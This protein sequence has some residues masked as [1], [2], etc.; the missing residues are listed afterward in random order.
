M[1]R[2][3]DHGSPP[4]TAS[5]ALLVPRLRGRLRRDGDLRQARLRRRRRRPHAAVRALRDRG[6]GAV[7]RR[8]AAPRARSS[9]ADRA[10]A[11]RRA[12]ARRDRLRAAGR[13]L[14]RRARA[15]GR[16]AALAAA[17]HVPRVRDR[18]RRS[19]SAAR[20]P[21][22]RRIGALLVSS[23]GLALVLLGAG[24]RRRSTGSAPPWASAPRSPTRPTSSSPTASAASF[25][26]LPLSA[27]VTTGAAITFGLAGAATGSLD[28]GFAERGL[29]VARRDR[30]RL[31][32]HADRAVL[33]RAAARRPVDGR[34]PLDARAA[35]H[36]R[37]GVRGVRRDADRV[38]LAGGALVLGAVV[39]LHVRPVSAPAAG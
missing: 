7:G 16:L 39:V 22:R 14:L 28:A 17:L 36:R 4:A 6:A 38:Q 15:D 18:R 30:A 10:H 1:R 35:D 23:G 32:G 33:R 5:A 29:A 24:A 25:D 26:A 9:A 27:L 19:R 31:D 37:A 34:D 11:A 12:R 3:A 8:A 20:P 2:V 13:P 21:S